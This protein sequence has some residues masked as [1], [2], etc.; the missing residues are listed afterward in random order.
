MIHIDETRFFEQRETP[1]T[2]DEARHLEACDACRGAKDEFAMLTANLA[3]QRAWRGA[4][5]PPRGRLE[6]IATIAGRLA[7]QRAEAREFGSSIAAASAEELPQLVASVRSAGGIQELLA[8]TADERRRSP[9]RALV[10]A[11]RAVQASDQLDDVSDTIR[12][13]LQMRS[14]TERA[15][16]LRLVGRFAEALASLDAADEIANGGAA[17]AFELAISWYTRAIVLREIDRVDEALGFAERA[18]KSFSEHGDD[19]RVVYCDVVLGMIAYRSGNLEPARVAFERGLSFVERTDD[20][21]TLASLHNNLAQVLVDMNRSEDAA[22]HFYSAIQ[23]HAAL[24]NDGSRWKANWGLARTL[25]ASGHTTEAAERLEE[26][27]TAFERLGMRDDANRVRLDLVEAFL[28]LGRHA[29]AA[30]NAESL[31]SYFGGIG[32]AA[33]VLN[34]VAQL[35]EAVAAGRATPGSAGQVRTY[36]QRLERE[37]EIL[38]LSSP[39]R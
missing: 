26:C 18:R 2:T 16:V 36:L 31:V 37:P 12:R 11:E 20:T 25:L 27:R 34:A 28:A 10:M 13:Q 32:A 8:R 33:S 3:G 30:P 22:P 23:L 14:R 21:Q 17:T 24:G 29:D 1:F 38:F 6:E 7:S 15:M 4:V 19:L 9:E 39:Q 35:R 5:T